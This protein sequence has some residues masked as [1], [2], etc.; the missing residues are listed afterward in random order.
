MD[1]TYDIFIS[2]AHEDEVFARPF[3]RALKGYYSARNGSR[4][5]LAIFWDDTEAAVNDLDKGIAEAIKA[6][7]K[8]IVVCSPAA[9]KS[10]WVNKEVKLFSEC[11]GA[12]NIIPILISGDPSSAFPHS[13]SVLFSQEPWAP[14]FRNG[15][16]SEP[17]KNKSAWYHLLAIIYGVS[18]AEIERRAFYKRV[19]T[20][21]LGG[22]L[23]IGAGIIAFVLYNQQ[24]EKQSIALA[25]EAAVPYRDE[26]S[27]GQR[28]IKAAKAMDA[29]DTRQAHEIASTLLTEMLEKMNKN[30][31]EMTAAENSDYFFYQNRFGS[32]ILYNWKTN[33]STTLYR[34]YPIPGT[35]QFTN[36]GKSLLIADDWGNAR[37]WDVATKKLQL[38]IQTDSTDG[39]PDFEF[40]PDD[41][42]LIITMERNDRYILEIWDV[43]NGKLV[44]DIWTKRSEKFCVD[45]IK[46]EI[47]F[48]E[49]RS[50][51]QKQDIVE[52][53]NYRSG[54]FHR[55]SLP[56]LSVLEL[57]EIHPGKGELI[58]RKDR[59]D[60]FAIVQINK[61][62]SVRNISF[63]EHGQ[64]TLEYNSI[65]YIESQYRR[66][67]P[68]LFSTGSVA[69]S[70]VNGL[71]LAANDDYYLHATHDSTYLYLFD[72]NRRTLLDSM[73]W[74]FGMIG[75]D[76]FFYGDNRV[77]LQSNKGNR[78]Y[79]SFWDLNKRTLL[80]LDSSGITFLRL[81][82]DGR[83]FVAN[84]NTNGSADDSSACF[85]KIFDQNGNCKA[86]IGA[87]KH[88]WTDVTPLDSSGIRLL[89]YSRDSVFVW[90]VNRPPFVTSL[91]FQP[92]SDIKMFEQDKKRMAGHPDGKQI[93]DIARHWLTF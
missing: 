82:A 50:G 15:S 71:L 49:E 58:F 77:A 54:E 65:K 22:F 88:F 90:N 81:L 9:R 8:M 34:N 80:N 52:F 44:K 72:L 92:E 74:K 18:R 32:G 36:N 19:F 55:T 87:D 62:Y 23:L 2:Y 68:I 76:H 84:K 26:F 1:K 78:T 51:D 37:I 35:I 53:C 16:P 85:I 56:I 41:L 12:E 5:K 70:P 39:T 66:S 64:N 91:P 25:A 45:T 7:R 33:L 11:H 75:H 42:S 73:R 83:H 27:F 6:S 29:A 20:L 24:Q 60:I 10:E 86:E 46:K 63:S 79:I 61:D 43:V 21:I 13:F 93:L 57:I 28:L 14:D 89:T 67:K 40:T 4:K 47:V 31:S 59:V 48:K 69:V 38:T 3:F 30:N 17:R